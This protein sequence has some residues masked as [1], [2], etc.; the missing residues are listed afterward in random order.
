MTKAALN[1]I[2]TEIKNHF[3]NF[4]VA[5][6][7]GKIDEATSESEELLALI[8]ERNSKCKRMK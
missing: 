4:K 5:I 2:E 6:R 3:D 8:S 7:E 1:D